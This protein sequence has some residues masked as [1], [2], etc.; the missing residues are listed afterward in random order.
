MYVI[1]SIKRLIIPG[2]LCVVMLVR[3]V[4][5]GIVVTSRS[6]CGVIMVARQ[7]GVGIVVT[8]ES[9]NGVKVAHWHG[10]P[11]MWECQR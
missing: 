10:M 2:G 3:Q 6:L 8:S 1:V 11:D 5:V 4:G 9:L 7:V